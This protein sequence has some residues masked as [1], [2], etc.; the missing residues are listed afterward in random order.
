MYFTDTYFH[1]FRNLRRGRV[2]WDGRVNLIIGHN[3]AGKTNFIEGLNIISGWGPISRGVKISSLPRWGG[4]GAASLW[5]R[6]AGEEDAD[7]FASVSGR[8]SLKIGD[9][10]ASASSMRLVIPVMTFLSDGMA[11][12]TGSSSARRALLDRVGALAVPGYAEAL[13]GY[14][15]ALKQK[16]VLLRQR[17]SAYSADRV[18]SPLCGEIWLARVKIVSMIEE[19]LE[20][21]SELLPHP[22]GLS[23][24]KGGS[25]A[26][27]QICGFDELL[28]VNAERE[29]ASGYALVGAQRDDVGIACGGM[30]ACRFL[31]RGQ[32]RRAAAALILASALAV[33]RAAKRKP[34][35]IFDEVTSELDAEG[36]VLLL[37]AL[38]KTECQVFAATAD[39][40]GYAGASVR[41]MAGGS[42]LKPQVDK[43]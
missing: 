10:A 28:S 16:S 13:G 2:S 24:V 17:R 42:F 12:I 40:I 26:G 38:V 19:A 7:I 43:F 32:S 18:M 3:G 35:L 8:C 23:F 29:R 25:S 36:R 37:G 5:A 20:N 22:I 33:E 4:G 27:S 14:K 9:R 31:S 41:R 39:E 30:E 34:V 1:D 6:A 21:F 15:R 11:V